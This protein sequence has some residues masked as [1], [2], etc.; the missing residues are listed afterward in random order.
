MPAP[1]SAPAGGAKPEKAKTR[2]RGLQGRFLP[3]RHAW[4]SALHRAPS[5]KRKPRPARRCRAPDGT[6]VKNARQLLA[7]ARHA[8]TP[9]PSRR[10]CAW[11]AMHR[12][13]SCSSRSAPRARAALHDSGTSA[14]AQTRRRETRSIASTSV[15][16]R[17]HRGSGRRRIL[18]APPALTPHRASDGPRHRHRRIFSARGAAVSGRSGTAACTGDDR[19]PARTSAALAAIM[20]QRQHEGVP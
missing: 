14:A 5:L 13:A 12:C 4:P 15:C 16:T 9:P 18:D 19:S 20:R 17:A 2:R 3:A 1:P 11:R 7:D 6:A 8:F 10:R